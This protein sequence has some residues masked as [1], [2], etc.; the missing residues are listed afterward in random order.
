MVF[1]CNTFERFGNL[2]VEKNFAD[3][4]SQSTDVIMIFS[5]DNGLMAG[6]HFNNDVAVNRFKR[7]DIHQCDVD[8][9]F[10]QHF[11]GGQAFLNHDTGSEYNQVGAFFYHPALTNLKF[12]GTVKYALNFW[13]TQAEIHRTIIFCESSSSLHG[14]FPICRLYDNHIGN[15]SSIGNIDNH[16]CCGTIFTHCESCMCAD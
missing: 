15:S 6:R 5:G 14:F 4:I 8:A 9:V 11:H 1:Y 13:T 10:L 7:R 12:I 3:S 2:R 16:L